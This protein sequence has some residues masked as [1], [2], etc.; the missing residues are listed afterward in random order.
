MHRTS[1]L[2]LVLSLIGCTGNAPPEVDNEPMNTDSDQDGI[3]ADDDCDD[4]NNTL[5]AMSSDADCDGVLT[6]DD[7]N[8]TDASMPN[9]DADCDGALTTDDCDDTDSTLGDVSS[10]A[11]CDGILTVDDCDDGDASSLTVFIDP[12]CDGFYLASNGVTVRCPAME[13]GATGEVDGTTYTKGDRDTVS[14]LLSTS[15]SDIPVVCTSGITDMSELFANEST[16]NQ[17]INSW[18]VSHV[19]NMYFM[20]FAAS[21]FNQDISA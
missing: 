14:A 7:C 8:D 18:D 11:D 20:F 17:D 6:I 1:L 2:L 16:F 3:L 4:F 21:A 13:I 15:P 9:D 5:G 19:T 12:E 10:D